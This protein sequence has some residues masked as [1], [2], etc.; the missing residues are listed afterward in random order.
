MDILEKF[1]KIRAWFEQED[2][3]IRQREGKPFFRTSHGLWGAAGML[4]MF[5]FFLKTQGY[6]ETHD[7]SFADYGSGDGRIVLIAALFMPATGIE[8]QENLTQIALK[9]KAELVQEIPELKRAEFKTA[10]YYEEEHNTYDF[11]FF[12]PDHPFPEAFQEKLQKE[13][14]GHLLVYNKIHSPEKIA[15]GKTYW[16]Q[17]VPIM[18]FP[19]NK[20][21]K[22]LFSSP[23]LQDKYQ[24]GST[25]DKEQ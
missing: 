1:Y 11:I 8:G 6:I 23:F 24:Q 14:T 25:N 12:F 5:E 3:R 15:K 21:E 16:I 19:I 2:A 22:D 17:Q 13:F 18:S 10:D 7:I 20:E 4:D 9:A